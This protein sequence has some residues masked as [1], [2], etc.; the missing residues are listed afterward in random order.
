MR[1][2][3]RSTPATSRVGC[4]AESGSPRAGGPGGGRGNSPSAWTIAARHAWREEAVRPEGRRP[5]PLT[6]QDD[7][8][9]V[10]GVAAGALPVERHQAHRASVNR[11][12]PCDPGA[13]PG[14]TRGR[15]WSP[16]SGSQS[17]RPSVPV[18]IQT[19]AGTPL[20]LR[21]AAAHLPHE[22]AQLRQLLLQVLGHVLLPLSP[23]ANNRNKPLLAP[24]RPRRSPCAPHP[25]Q[26]SPPPPLRLGAPLPPPRAV[27]RVR[28][29]KPSPPPVGPRPRGRPPSFPFPE[30]GG[31]RRR[32][33]L[34]PAAGAPPGA[35][36]GQGG[37]GARNSS[38]PARPCPHTPTNPL[39]AA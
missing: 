3:N 36:G 10:P 26:N 9:Y 32:R 25:P 2:F 38:R 34:A 33:E 15:S 24:R 5:V 31:G 20:P 12:R 17:P 29:R 7:D 13:P 6:A 18:R 1:A 19:Q 14:R 27:A 39:C 4:A 21:Y 11:A 28:G 23:F 16:C 30:E 37:Q 22:A 35:R 8:R